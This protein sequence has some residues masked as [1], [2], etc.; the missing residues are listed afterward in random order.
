M[1][2]RGGTHLPTEIYDIPSSRGPTYLQKCRRK[3]P[4]SSRAALAPA[5]SRAPEEPTSTRACC[6][7]AGLGEHRRADHVA[8][9]AACR[10]QEEQQLEVMPGR[11]PLGVRPSHEGKDAAGGTGMTARRTYVLEEQLDAA[12]AASSMRCCCVSRPPGLL[13]DAKAAA[14]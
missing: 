14:G 1:T 11:S 2:A 10:D 13:L 3:P 6:L 8:V 5:R 12:A 9:A 4:Q 7:V